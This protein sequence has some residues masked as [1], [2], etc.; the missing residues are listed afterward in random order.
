MLS[1]RDFAKLTLASAPFALKAAAAEPFRLGAATESFHELPHVPGRDNVDT[2]IA[3]L[4]ASGVT[5]IDLS[6]VNT[7]APDPDIGMPP[8]PPPGPYGGPPGGFTPAELA[9][10]NRAV[11]NNLRKWRLATPP[12]HYAEL[13]SKFQAANIGVYAMSFVHDD[14]FTDEEL[15]ATFAHSK[16]L[17]VEVISSRASFAMAK[18]LALFAGKYGIPVAIRNDRETAGQLAE[19]A[20]ISP[21]FRVNLDI[22][23]FTAANQESVAFIQ[24]HHDRITHLIVKDR[25]RNNGDNE[26]FGAG[27]TPIRPVLALLRE[28]QFPIR[29]YVDYEY[30]GLGTPQE[31]VRRCLAYLKASL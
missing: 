30:V 24:E 21:Q 11:R 28:K 22:G 12:A 10:R 27:D 31:E 26:K 16:A 29:A 1:R 15:D 23:N 8:P 17:G 13:K 20:A 7:E 3:A 14:D 2:I 18:R 4:H 25:T 19:M 9:A 5:E 6:S